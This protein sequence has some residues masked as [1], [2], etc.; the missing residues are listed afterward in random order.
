MALLDKTL[1]K[2]LIQFSRENQTPS[3]VS[4]KILA[5]VAFYKNAAI[6]HPINMKLFPL[7]E[8]WLT[9]YIPSRSCTKVAAIPAFNGKFSFPK[10]N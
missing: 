3:I 1:L 7:F 5:M 4:T 9:Q 2:R 10:M 6:C 8:M